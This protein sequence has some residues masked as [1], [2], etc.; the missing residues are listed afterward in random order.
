MC[1]GILPVPRPCSKHYREDRIFSNGFSPVGSKAG[2]RGLLWIS[3]APGRKLPRGRQN[4]L[5]VETPPLHYTTISTLALLASL[6]LIPPISKCAWTHCSSQHTH[7]LVT[8]KRQQR[9]ESN[10]V[11]HLSLLRG[12]WGLLWAQ[13]C[14]HWTPLLFT[15]CIVVQSLL[16]SLHGPLKWAEYNPSVAQSFEVTYHH[17]T[18]I[19]KVQFG[20]K[21]PFCHGMFYASIWL[22]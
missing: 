16:R 3:H 17:F 15:I 10:P 18:I 8:V 2:G 20:Q 5:F 13:K 6:N 14:A 1:V 4:S 11:L 21:Q 19:F 22:L 12:L 9:E 7:P